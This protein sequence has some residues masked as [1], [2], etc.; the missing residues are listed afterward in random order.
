MQ[1]AHPDPGTSRT[2]ARPFPLRSGSR[3]ARALR[4][5][6]AL[7]LVGAATLASPAPTLAADTPHCSA[8]AAGG[9]A[10][11]VEPIGSTEGGTDAS[12]FVANPIDVVTGNKYQHRLD[13]R[14]FGSRLA[15]S[16]HYNSARTDVDLGLGR[17]WRHDYDVS[18]ARVDETGLRVF[19]SDG[20][21][22]D[23]ELAGVDAA[24][25]AGIDADALAT[26]AVPYLPADLADG[27]VLLGDDAAWGMVDGRE[28]RFR[29]RY[30][31]GVSWPDGDR[32]ALRYDRAG[33]LGSVTDR[34][35]RTVRLRY[36]PGRAVLDGWDPATDVT[37]PGHLERIELPNGEALEYRYDNRRNLVRV[38]H[39]GQTIERLT[40]TDPDLPNHLTGLDADGESK[41]WHYDG[42]G[43]GDGYVDGFGSALMLEYLPEPADSSGVRV[44]RTLVRRRDGAY[45]DYR[46]SMDAGGRGEVTSVI[47]HGCATCAGVPR[48][49]TRRRGSADV[50]SA[51]GGSAARDGSPIAGLTIESLGADTATVSADGLSGPVS[52]GFDRRG[53]PVRV[54]S[55]SV[56]TDGDAV[57]E[58]VLRLDGVGTVDGAGVAYATRKKA[59]CPPPVF[60]TCDE[61][62][63]DQQMAL[64]SVC[65]YEAPP[66][67]GADIGDW[68]VV[69]YDSLGMQKEDFIQTNQ[70][71]EEVGMYARPYYNKHTDELV[72]AFR[73]TEPE[74]RDIATDGRQFLH[75]KSDQYDR[76]QKLAQEVAINGNDSVT[77]T[78]HSLGGGLA[79]TAAAS[80]AQQSITFNPAALTPKTA[81]N[82]GIPY[83]A[84]HAAATNYVVPGELLTEAQDI[85]FVHLELFGP[86]RIGS[87]PAPGQRYE[88]Q[89]PDESVVQDNMF[90]APWIMRNHPFTRDDIRWLERAGT[91]HTSGPVLSAMEETISHQCGTTSP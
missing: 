82:L 47:E 85:P 81:D 55:P 39:A 62:V 15:F 22:I 14:A 75:G 1:A 50:G 29:G 89:P 9:P 17:G 77:Y 24:L 67:G 36:T 80:T 65:V 5:R 48:P 4:A 40:Y 41:R 49:T 84:A 45:L 74:W 19:Q 61:L 37:L 71:G 58:A 43:R 54:D 7:L 87:T 66:C 76:A 26:G 83:E 33:R 20:R 31:V 52:V 64:L 56:D 30:L 8:F 2:T 79:T 18:L 23:F 88:M 70:A 53:R 3:F 27:H 86:A 69:S 68:E 44:G 90:K 63:H 28:L 6:T 12:R 42:D 25:E 72:V 13:Y 46:W 78:G 60:R 73:G 32:L 16:R 59:N 34:H 10:C 11:G 51:D 21:Q 35:D 91:L 38:D 57:R